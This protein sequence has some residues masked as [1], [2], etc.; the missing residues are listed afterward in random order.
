VPRRFVTLDVFTDVPFSG[1]PLAVIGDGEGLGVEQMQSIAREFNLSETTFVLPP[2]DPAN[3]AR[4]RIFTPNQELP[5]AG[6]PTIGTAIQIATERSGVGRHALRLEEGVGLIECDVTIS[7]NGPSGATFPVPV[8]ATE[9]RRPPS[10]AD[11]AAL[12][13]LAP[14][15]I[16]CGAH[17]PSVYDGGLPYTLVPLSGLD[18]IGRVTPDL[19]RWP[20]VV[21]TGLHNSVYL[22]T[23]ETVRGGNDFHARMFWPAVGLRED[24]ATG[25]AASSFVGA[26]DAF[27]S[28]SEGTHQ[29]VIEQGFEM[30]RPSLITVQTDV[31]GGAVTAA[32][33][34]GSAVSVSSGEIHI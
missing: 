3:T 23:T 9:V 11:L 12:L 33:I 29:H 10:V 13:G 15:D 19:S 14:V 2:E 6:H 27:E 24:P 22:Y 7:E 5:F 8:L 32:R 25:S 20:E 34:G 18:A 4:V 17:Q 1:N 30:G 26:I 21:G 31:S 16:G 28:L